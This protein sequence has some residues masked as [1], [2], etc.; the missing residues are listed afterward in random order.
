[1]ILAI[2]V[3]SYN[4]ECQRMATEKTADPYEVVG[5]GYID[6]IIPDA[7]RAGS[8]AIPITFSS[9]S[10]YTSTGRYTREE[11]LTLIRINPEFKSFWDE[12][13]CSINGDLSF[14]FYAFGCSYMAVHHLAK[15]YGLTNTVEYHALIEE[16][17]EGPSE[18]AKM[19]ADEI[20]KELSK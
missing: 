18:L 4:C 12:F 14:L 11:F 5:T 2:E 1:M 9:D 13:I 17:N 6:S 7:F 15:E 8:R 10:V 20:I 3:Q 19:I 16:L